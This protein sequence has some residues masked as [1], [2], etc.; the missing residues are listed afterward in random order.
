MKK[1]FFTLVIALVSLSTT[2]RTTIAVLPYTI[3]YEGRIP[4]KYTPEQLEEMRKQDGEIYQQFMINY[5]NK[6]G[7]KK[8]NWTLDINV[9]SQSDLTSILNKNNI[10]QTKID[11]LTNEELANVL[12]VTYIIRGSVTR[13]FIMSDELSL[14]ITAVSAVTKQP[15]YNTTSYLNILNSL[16]DSQSSRTLF[17]RVF[18]RSTTAIKTDERALRDTF[19]KSSRK[20]CRKLRDVI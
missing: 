6:M 14:G 10:K 15:L 12:G 3:S 11:S 19:R 9:L 16:H 13:T 1:L 20:M 7:A 5:L 18:I 2:A 8:K 4:T 17:S